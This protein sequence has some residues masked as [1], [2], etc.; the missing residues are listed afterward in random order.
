MIDIKVGDKLTRDCYSEEYF[1]EVLCIGDNTFYGRDFYN[2]E[3]SIDLDS[4]WKHYKDEVTKDLEGVF[5]FYEVLKQ[6]DRIY[7]KPLLGNQSAF[8]HNKGF[9][10][11]TFETITEKEA[12]ERGL[13]V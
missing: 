3:S 10:S 5:K 11:D 8:D 12:I 1:V 13:K 6:S 9:D 2:I 4:G 7:V